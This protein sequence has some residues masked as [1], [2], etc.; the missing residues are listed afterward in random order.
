MSAHPI[1]LALRFILELAALYALGYWGWTQH[2][3]L[4]DW[5]MPARG[6]YNLVRSLTRPYVGAHAY[7]KS[8]PFKIW[9]VSEKT[10][11]HSPFAEPGKVVGIDRTANS[12]TVK[13][14]TD[15]INVIDHE[16][17]SLP[18]AGDYL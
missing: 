8:K 18:N 14:G 4:V 16:L 6:I 3:G 9:S 7:Y 1:N 10:C 13:C 2:D 15:A 17:Q 5:R 11:C 12:F